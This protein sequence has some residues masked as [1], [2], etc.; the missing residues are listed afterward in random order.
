MPLLFLQTAVF[1]RAVAL[2]LCTGL[3]GAAHAQM[4][5]GADQKP[6]PPEASAKE[7][8][9][10]PGG[11]MPIGITVSGDVVFPFQCKGFI[12]RQ[13]TAEGKPS[14]AEEK[15]VATDTST[16]QATPA[17]EKNLSAKPTNA[18]AEGKSQLSAE[19]TKQARQ[20]PRV[21]TTSA[22]KPADRRQADS[23][24]E[25]PS[26][27]QQ[28]GTARDQES[29]APEPVAQQNGQPQTETTETGSIATQAKQKSRACTQ[30]R[31]YNPQSGTY[32]GFDGQRHSCG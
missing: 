21:R 28:N 1:R 13:K 26:S 6:S 4:A 2:V 29:A 23:R 32:T 5:E 30:F 31:S 24:E 14:V 11:C 17:P 9:P 25:K 16:K 10:P 20:K 12:E 19:P 18:P 22:Q 8:M 15:P 27:A 3:S 7:D